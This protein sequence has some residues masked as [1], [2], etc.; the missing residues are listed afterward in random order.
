MMRKCIGGIAILL[1]L[2]SSCRQEIADGTIVD[3]DKAFELKLW[4]TLDATSG[5]LQI[6][7]NSIKQERCGS[8]LRIN[9]S[10]QTPDGAL[11]INLAN[12]TDTP[13]NCGNINELVHDTLTCG[14]MRNG[15]YSVQI[16]LKN[17]VISKGSLTVRDDRYNLQ[18]LQ[19]NGI[20]VSVPTL[21]RIPQNTL[22]GSIS[23]DNG[24]EYVARAFSDSLAFLTTPLALSNGNYGFFNVENSVYQPF[25]LV[26]TK[27]NATHFLQKLPSDAKQKLLNL[28]AQF[29]N[30]Y[31]AA[32]EITL[33]SQ[34]GMRF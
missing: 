27:P 3:V 9:N 31:G 12:Y 28:V 34:E 22:F 6:A 24:F 21:Q 2:L 23:T 11:I 16:S 26:V 17:A 20:K 1:M 4:Q 14:K 5:T 18:M 19:E 33:L 8:L 7:V 13:N 25:S 32:I 29:R 30:R 10:V 15:I